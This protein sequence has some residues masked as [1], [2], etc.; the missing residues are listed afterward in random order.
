MICVDH[1]FSYIL[2]PGGT[3]GETR[4]SHA[5]TR[6]SHTYCCIRGHVAFNA[7]DIYVMIFIDSSDSCHCRGSNTRFDENPNSDP[8][9]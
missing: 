1:S 5:H 6:V 4:A 7:N 9:L 3:L 2:Y 8:M